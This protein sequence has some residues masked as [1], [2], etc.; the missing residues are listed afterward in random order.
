MEVK[1]SNLVPLW[2][3]NTGK[4]LYFVATEIQERCGVAQ[5]GHVR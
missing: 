1:Y 5:I 4:A 2:D 3:F